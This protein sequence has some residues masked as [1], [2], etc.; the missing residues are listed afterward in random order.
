MPS[1][2]AKS[3]GPGREYLRALLAERN[4]HPDRVADI[5][6]LIEETFRRKVAILVLDMSGFTRLTL[7]YGIIHYLAMIEQ[8]DNAARPAVAQNAGIVIKQEADNIFAVFDSPAAAIEAARDILIA[9]S[10]VNT[11]VPDERDL[12]ASFGIGYG[13]TLVVDDHDMFGSEVNAACKLGEDLADR[14]EILLTPA[15]HDAIPPNL[16]TFEPRHFS[17]SGVDLASWKFIDVV[18]DDSVPMD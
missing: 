8:M 9:F 3:T 15:A 16:Y 12:Y 2:H 18:E 5:D 10:A 11:V 4:Q 7:K 1:E 17:I 14:Y 13:D 6:R